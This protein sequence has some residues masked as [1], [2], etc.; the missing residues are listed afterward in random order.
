MMVR[1]QISLEKEQA[2]RLRELAAARAMSQSAIIREALD[3]QIDRVDRSEKYQRLISAA[4][5]F[6]SEHADTSANHDE[7]LEEAFW[8]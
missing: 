8:E 1:T 5:L 4:G 7:T 2:E 6:R 3:A